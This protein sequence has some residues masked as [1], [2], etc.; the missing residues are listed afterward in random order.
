[1]DFEHLV[2]EQRDEPSVSPRAIGRELE[3]VDPEKTNTT[4]FIA[5]RSDPFP[6][7]RPVE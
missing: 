5:Y 7:D 6:E 4:P 3:A 1:L 2:A